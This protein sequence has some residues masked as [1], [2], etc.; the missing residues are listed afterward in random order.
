MSILDIYIYS[1]AFF[2]VFLENSFWSDVLIGTDL[3]FITPMSNMNSISIL[4]QNE[5]NTTAF[6][7][8]NLGRGFIGPSSCLRAWDV[9]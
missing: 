6:T 7:Q 2:V 3:D 5:K 9:G 4:C 1:A 8:R